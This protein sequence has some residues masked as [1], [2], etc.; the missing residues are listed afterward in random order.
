[1]FSLSI[2]ITGMTQPWRLLFKDEASIKLATV[3]L[4]IGSPFSCVDD[5]GQTVSVEKVAAALTE[6][7]DKSKH[8]AVA[9]MLYN[10]GLQIEA[11][12]KAQQMAS[13]NGPAVITPGM[14]GVP[15]GPFRQ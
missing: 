1:M 3:E 14:A 9:L 4:A 13:A 12:R 11:Q 5:F 8:A 7:L 2:A 10:H 6:D 15:S